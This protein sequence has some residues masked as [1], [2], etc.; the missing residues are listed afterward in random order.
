MTLNESICRQ[1]RHSFEQA[2]AEQNGHDCR[3]GAELK[4]PLVN[5]DGSAASLESVC[6]L[7]DYLVERGW[8]PVED[9]L[10]GNIVGATKPGEENDTVASC[11]TGF[12]KTE[13]SLAHVADLHRLDRSICE[14]RE[15]L[16]PFS[17]RQDVY[18]LGYGI[19][20]VTPPSKRLLMRKGRTSVW[21]KVFRSNRHISEEDGDDVH[22]FTINTASHVHVSVPIKKAVAAVN[23]LNGFAGA[24]IALTADSNIWRGV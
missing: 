1:F 17:E 23:V 9:A 16:R 19:H 6:A 18:F 3:I 10:T 5:R 4:F 20:P 11:E 21:D 13:F 7:W 24:Q 8:K 14:L 22:L 15:E 2:I 12:C